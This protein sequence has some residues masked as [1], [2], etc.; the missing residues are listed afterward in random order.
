MCC[1]RL[2]KHLSPLD[3]CQLF[4]PSYL[5]DI[6]TCLCWFPRLWMLFDRLMCPSMR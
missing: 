4:G 2:C 6:V 5:K 1:F 3:L